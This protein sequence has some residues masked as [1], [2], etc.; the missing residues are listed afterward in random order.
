MKIFWTRENDHGHIV[1]YSE[2]TRTTRARRRAGHN[3]VVGGH[4]I[5]RARFRGPGRGKKDYPDGKN[6]KRTANGGRAD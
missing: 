1:F 2:A 3:A 6:P 5:D 4:G